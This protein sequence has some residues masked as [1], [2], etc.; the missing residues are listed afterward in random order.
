MN[1]LTYLLDLI[2]RGH[3]FDILYNG[4]HCIGV[5]DKKIFELGNTFKKDIIN[6]Y[7][8]NGGNEYIE[9]LTTHN[10]K[11]IK[12]IFNLDIRYSNIL[13]RMYKTAKIN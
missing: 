2:G 13:D 8:I 7:S 6:G 5:N 1:C 10:K 3:D 11:T 4:N 9:I 12:K